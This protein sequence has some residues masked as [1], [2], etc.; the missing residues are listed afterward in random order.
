MTGICEHCRRYSGLVKDAFSL[1]VEQR[2]AFQGVFVY[3]QA[4][5]IGIGSYL[6]PD[7]FQCIRSNSLR[8]ILHSL[9]FTAVYCIKPE[10]PLVLGSFCSTPSD[11]RI[12]F[13]FHA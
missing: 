8:L 11:T 13:F 5:Y 3:L 7:A 6:H 12:Y 1:A 9:M 4:T 2:S 10:F